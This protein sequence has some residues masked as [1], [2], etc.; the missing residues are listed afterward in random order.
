MEYELNEI[1]LLLES[2]LGKSKN[3][4]DE[5]TQIQFNCP[6][7]SIDK[8]MENGDGK[9]NLEVNIKKNIFKCW[10]CGDTNEMSGRIPNLIK[11][12]G[13]NDILNKYKSILY[14]IRQS[15]LYKFKFSNNDFNLDN[16]KEETIT[17]PD[18]FTKLNN[19]NTNSIQAL[20]YLIKRGI[21]QKII[22]KYNIG[23]I[24]IGFPLGG[25]IIIPSYDSF[26]CLN[27]WVGR[28]FLNRKNVIKYAN[29]KSE[30]TKKTNII[31]NEG[32]INPYADINIVEGPFDHIVVPN[33]IPLLGK[34]LK[35]NYAIYNF[36][37]SNAKA[38]INIFLD[39][40]AIDNAKKIYKLLNN[41]NLK[42]RIKITESPK[43]YDASLIYEK[44]GANGIRSVLM[45]QHSISE[46]NLLNI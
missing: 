35:K 44:Y 3:G 29:P 41:G 15:N 17:L 11:R 10:V 25:R 30:F 13:N 33:S 46:F 16:F 38:K 14:K 19:R 22:N 2:F 24:P 36:L 37:I 21:S 18:G 45:S 43:G 32:K 34:S 1:L 8:N 7:C 23:Y 26:G 42:G 12:F 27:Y 28:D 40:D 31:F 4:I 39:D 20:N 5:N 9:Y 6:M